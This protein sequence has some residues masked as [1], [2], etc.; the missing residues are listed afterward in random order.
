MT[1]LRALLTCF[2]RWQCRTFGHSFNDIG[3]LMFNIELSALNR[4]Q[5]HPA[6]ACR[7]C[8]DV[9]EAK[10]ADKLEQKLEDYF[11]TL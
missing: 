11:E 2:R 9:F 6:I 3:L 8:G 4:D 1:H 10:D 7:R 5:L